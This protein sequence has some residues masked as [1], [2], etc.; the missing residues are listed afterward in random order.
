MLHAFED[1]VDSHERRDGGAGGQGGDTHTTAAPV[2]I[3]ARLGEQRARGER[4]DEDNQRKSFPRTHPSFLFP[5]LTAA[6]VRWFVSACTQIVTEAGG[7][8][9]L[10][11]LKYN[12][13]IIIKVMKRLQHAYHH[14]LTKRNALL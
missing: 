14:A 3:A 6:A 5:A 11:P 1:A 4:E 2:D 13:P 8:D 12:D 7:T 10:R 9:A